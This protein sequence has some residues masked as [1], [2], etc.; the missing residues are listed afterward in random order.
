MESC[1]ANSETSAEW[2]TAIEALAG[3]RGSVIVLGAPGAGKSTFSLYLLQKLR[4]RVERLAFVD[5]DLGQSHLGP[6]STMNM[7]IVSKGDGA[8]GEL[9][10]DCMRFV[11]SVSPSGFL[12][13]TVVS[14]KKLVDKAF[15]NGATLVIIDTSGMVYGGAAREL[16]FHQFELIG[17]K[18]IV[19]LQRTSEI[20]HI[21]TPLEK[22]GVCA[23]LRLKAPAMA[24]LYTR[25]Q[26]RKLRCERFASYFK[27]S[28]LIEVDV[29]TISIYGSYFGVGELLEEVDRQY[30]SAGLGIEIVYGERSSSELFFIANGTPK[31]VDPSLFR[32]H[33]WLKWVRMENLEEYANR[34]VGLCDAEKNCLAIG[35][36]KKFDDRFRTL[37]LLSPI[38]QES[39]SKI[40][41][42]QFGSLRV[43]D[44]GEEIWPRPTRYEFSAGEA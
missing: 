27:D 23:V 41:A 40:K 5:C 3:L 17:P 36:I 11:G 34:L 19:A 6:P 13:Q 1:F 8:L 37:A 18:A 29:G 2:G 24:K 33:Q 21:L 30:Y 20:E 9:K 42:I 7:A 43:D 10:P 22:Q 38:P 44:S 26:R 35:R 25:E 14:A 15:E 31:E 12:L 39:L 32:N 28:N 4:H 16:K